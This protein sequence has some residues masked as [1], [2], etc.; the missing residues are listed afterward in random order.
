MNFGQDFEAAFLARIETEVWSRLKSWNFD[1]IF[2]LKYGWDCEAKNWS[3][4]QELVIWSKTASLYNDESTQ[5]LGTLC[6]CQ[7][8]VIKEKKKKFSQIICVSGG[9]RGRRQRKSQG[10]GAVLKNLSIFDIFLRSS[11]ISFFKAPLI[12]YIVISRKSKKTGEFDDFAAFSGR[13]RQNWPE[14]RLRVERRSRFLLLFNLLKP[15]EG[16]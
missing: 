9:R 1:K 10:G 13:W 2:R 5:S 7:C 15:L 6:P 16:G 12:S 8:L 11:N 4:V 3:M 14:W